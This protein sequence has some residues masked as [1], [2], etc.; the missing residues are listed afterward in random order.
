MKN[1]L[2]AV[3]FSEASRK[4]TDY[5]AALA[6]AFNTNL[7]LVHA[8]YIPMPVGDAP[9]YIPLSMTE[10]QKE[11]EAF[12]QREL[13]YL[14]SRYEIRTDGY[15]RTGTTVSVIKELV[16]EIHAGLLV[17][18]MKG[19]GRSAAIFGSTVIAAIHK[20]RMPL[21]IV[22]EE[23]EFCFIK[24]TIFAA[25]FK[26]SRKVQR[27]ALL[28]EIAAHFNADVQVLHVQKNEAFM[29]AGQVAGKIGT[30]IAFDR[31][32]HT[33]HTQVDEDVERGITD[34]IS[35]HPTDLLVMVAHHHNFFERLFGKE[36][37][38]L[39]AYKTK[40]PLLVLHGD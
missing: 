35:T 28:E 26:E 29:E 32:K 22:P 8:Y 39:M 10:V 38:K 18:G 21:I 11:M 37:T 12:M 6:K 20:A 16:A 36:H 33:F 15:V 40:V 1:I 30:E 4:A 34:F 7:F 13:E 25:D 24:H 19:T 2:V 14:T 5:A 31:V 9:G 23:A 27:F 17:M 3:D